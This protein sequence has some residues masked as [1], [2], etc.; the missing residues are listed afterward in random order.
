MTLGGG[1]GACI[2]R[3]TAIHNH[4]QP[5]PNVIAWTPSTGRVR[6]GRRSER[7]CCPMFERIVYLLAALATIA[8]FLLEEWRTWKEHRE[9]RRRAD[10]D[11]RKR[12]G[13][14]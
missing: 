2:R 7:S 1:E 4:R 5:I 8:A 9:S 14:P 11:G 10:D 13:R 3:P 12:R 6:R